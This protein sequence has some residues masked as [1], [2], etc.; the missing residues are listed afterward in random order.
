MF[1]FL[2]LVTVR[3]ESFLALLRSKKIIAIY[4]LSRL[5][6]KK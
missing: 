5:E 2:G 3:R 4:I 1:Y 6:M